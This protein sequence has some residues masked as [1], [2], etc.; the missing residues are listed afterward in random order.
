MVDANIRRLLVLVKVQDGTK[1]V[2]EVMFRSQ[3]EGRA[4]APGLY[5]GQQSAYD[6]EFQVFQGSEEVAPNEK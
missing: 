5:A 6:N 1:R 2:K 3:Q 4:E